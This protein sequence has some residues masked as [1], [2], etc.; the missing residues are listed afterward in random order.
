[1]AALRSIVFILLF[2][3][4][5]GCGDKN[6]SNDS[7]RS[8]DHGTQG[9]LD[10]KAPNLVGNWT[11]DFEAMAD[12]LKSRYG[13]DALEKAKL[14]KVAMS[15]NAD[16]SYL[17]SATGPAGAPDNEQGTWNVMAAEGNVFTLELRSPK[18]T[19]TVK[20]T[21]LAEDRLSLTRDKWGYDMPLKRLP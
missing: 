18:E 15:F 11:I 19:S 17:F 16:G 10:D 3:C 8:A 2:G 7:G 14:M 4:F 20:A 13:P 1:M 9:K 12:L 6:E 5:F 21:I